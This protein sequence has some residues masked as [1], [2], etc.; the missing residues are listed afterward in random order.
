ME[1]AEEP[2]REKRGG[3][4][5]R[6]EIKGNGRLDSKEKNNRHKK[7]HGS[8]TSLLPR[9]N[10]LITLPLSFSGYGFSGVS[11]PAIGSRGASGRMT[12]RK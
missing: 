5:K 7:R 9:P 10:P 12:N 3:G 6:T 11:G 1:A 2:N 8:L 4:E